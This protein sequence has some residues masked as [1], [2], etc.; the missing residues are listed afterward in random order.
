MSWPGQ[1]SL[2]HIYTSQ[3]NFF[4]HRLRMPSLQ[5]LVT[6]VTKNSNRPKAVAFSNYSRQPA[7]YFSP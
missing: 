3:D 4:K 1:S 5:T 6:E 2:M 7:V